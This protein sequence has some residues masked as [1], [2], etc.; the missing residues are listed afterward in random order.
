MSNVLIGII[1]II[2]FI[3]LALAGALI[4]GDDFMSARSDS[5]AAASIS[6]MS[7]V[8]NAIAMYELKTGRKFVAGTPLATLM[9]RFLK[10]LPVNPTTAP[11]PGTYTAQVV[12]SGGDTSLVLMELGS[13]AEAVCMAISQQSGRPSIAIANDVASVPS[14]P[15]G[16]FRTSATIGSAK[17]STFYAYNWTSGSKP[18]SAGT[19]G[20]TGSTG[21]GGVGMVD[22]PACT[23]GPKGN[24]MSD[25]WYVDPANPDV[26]VHGYCDANGVPIK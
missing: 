6:M 8:S 5:K 13:E 11:I 14:Q 20:G 3:G 4:L 21:S 23:P 26:A 15:G 1:G 10:S 7:Q 16:C 17:G 18:A 2:L 12:N 22:Q 24:C 9:P 19:S 25:C